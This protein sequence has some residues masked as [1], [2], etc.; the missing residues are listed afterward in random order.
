MSVSCLVPDLSP[1]RGSKESPWGP[2]VR[3]FLPVTPSWPQMETVPVG[4]HHC[5]GPGSAETATR[6]VDS[7]VGPGT[8]LEELYVGVS[9]Y[10]SRF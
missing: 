7:S 2:E 1:H 9:K 4:E 8:Q 10:P 5:L 3:V 6:G